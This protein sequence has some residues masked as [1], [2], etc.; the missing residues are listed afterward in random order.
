MAFQQIGKMMIQIY[1]HVSL[2][3]VSVDLDG[4]PMDSTLIG[5]LPLNRAPVDSLDGCPM[6]W[7][8]LD[9]VPVDDI[10]GVPLGVVID[11]IDGMPC[12]ST[13]YQKHIFQP[14]VHFPVFNYLPTTNVFNQYTDPPFHG[15]LSVTE[16]ALWSP[17]EQGM[18][19]HFFTGVNKV[20]NI[21]K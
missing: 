21:I 11:D 12:E 4:A 14:E 20:I 15:L 10:D 1:V 9:G 5:G 13:T 16:C 19:I 8:P 6:G 17:W 7:D 2:Q 18:H 3:E